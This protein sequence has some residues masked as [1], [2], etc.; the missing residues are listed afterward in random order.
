MV[1]TFQLSICEILGHNYGDWETADVKGMCGEHDRYEEKKIC[2]RC[3]LHFF[4]FLDTKEATHMG[5][6]NFDVLFD[7]RNFKKDRYL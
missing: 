5:Y 4:R 2:K 1:T 3:G 6:S 7:I